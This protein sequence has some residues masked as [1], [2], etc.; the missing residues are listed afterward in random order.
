M[1]RQGPSA[2]IKAGFWT[3]AA[4]VL[5]PWLRCQCEEEEVHHFSVDEEAEASVWSIPASTARCQALRRLESFQNKGA[6]ISSFS[7][8]ICEIKGWFISHLLKSKTVSLQT[9][10]NV[11]AKCDYP[12]EL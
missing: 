12:L 6:V 5:S 9:R 10:R 3:P 11:P 2:L 1:Q 7:R 8:L 4:F